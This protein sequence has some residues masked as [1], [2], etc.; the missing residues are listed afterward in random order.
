MPRR[1]C[2]FWQPTRLSEADFRMPREC[3]VDI[4][5]GRRS[6]AS[7]RDIAYLVGGKFMRLS[8]RS[9]ASGRKLFVRIGVVIP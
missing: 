6:L 3:A 7:L 1:R 8:T 2:S 5:C 9:S 4:H